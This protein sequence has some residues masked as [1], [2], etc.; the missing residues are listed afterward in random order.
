VNAADS[1]LRS[2]QVRLDQTETE[3]RGMGYEVER[4]VSHPG[5]QL[6]NQ[7]FDGA[8][9]ILVLFGRLWTQS[10]ESV[11]ELGPGDRLYVPSGV[12]FSLRAEG[13]TPAYWIQGFKPDAR[14]EE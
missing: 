2:L 1:A 13:E 4:C 3:L 6:G 9:V 10:N 7:R 8:V 5:A 12:P 11:V 14:D